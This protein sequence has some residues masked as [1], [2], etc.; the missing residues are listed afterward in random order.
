MMFGLNPTKPYDGTLIRLPLRTDRILGSSS[1]SSRSFGSDQILQLI[2]S[3][4]Q[5]AASSLLFLTAVEHV[6]FSVCTANEGLQNLLD[7]LVKVPPR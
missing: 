4:K 6:N 1:V 3:F 7:V 2:D 5:Y